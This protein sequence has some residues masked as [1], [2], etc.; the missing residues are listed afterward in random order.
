M[1]SNRRIDQMVTKSTSTAA[2]GAM[3]G[4][5]TLGNSAAEL[6]PSS[7]AAS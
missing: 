2:D 3:L 6:A 4:K 7:R 1:T 5:V